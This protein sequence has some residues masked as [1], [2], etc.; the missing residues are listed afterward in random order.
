MR[1]TWG[2]VFMAVAILAAHCATTVS[3][4]QLDRCLLTSAS[5]DDA[6]REVLGAACR[7][8][9]ERFAEE[10]RPREAVACARKACE[11]GDALGCGHYLWLTH[12]DP[13]LEPARLAAARATGERS[14]EGDAM[15]DDRGRDLRILLCERTALL[16][17]DRVPIDA[18]LAGRM[19]LR[20][21]KLGDDSACRHAQALGIGRSAIAARDVPAASEVPPA[22]APST[23]PGAPAAAVTP[24]APAPATAAPPPTSRAPLRGACHDMHGCVTLSL[25]A[26]SEE[27]DL[28]GTLTSHCERAA[29]CTWCPAQGD[30]VDRSA[31]RSATLGPGERRYGQS[32]GLYYKGFSAI[33]YDCSDADD[34]ARCRSL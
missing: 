31:C 24:A 3:R 6:H 2:P 11:L 10:S 4:E 30:A 18:S 12:E 1:L 22:A 28:V 5:G 26:R 17:L 33:A 23:P 34:D 16:Y 20:A 29:T 19:Y 13:A 25:W 21:C 7:T 14:C 9:A 15:T 32:D 27:G 8:T